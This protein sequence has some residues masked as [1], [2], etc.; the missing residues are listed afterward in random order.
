MLG[1][2]LTAIPASPLKLANGSR[3]GLTYTELSA[4]G[5]LRRV[6]KLGPGHATFAC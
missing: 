2:D 1:L 4:F 5:I 6:E 3:M